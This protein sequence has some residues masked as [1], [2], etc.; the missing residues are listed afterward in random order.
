ML[1]TQAVQT[2]CQKCKGVQSSKHHKMPRNHCRSPTK[3]QHDEDE[4]RALLAFL[5]CYASLPMYYYNDKEPRRL[6]SFQSIHVLAQTCK[7]YQWHTCKTRESWENKLSAVRFLHLSTPIMLQDNTYMSLFVYTYNHLMCGNQNF[8]TYLI[9]VLLC[10]VRG[11]A[12]IHCF[13]NAMTSS[14]NI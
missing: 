13:Y 10:I 4:V 1:D 7:K 6:N 14:Q 2:Q 9:K 11:H 8:S 5:C 12:N 3:C